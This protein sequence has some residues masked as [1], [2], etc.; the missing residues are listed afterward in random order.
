MDRGELPCNN[1][2]GEANALAPAARLDWHDQ[3]PL[4]NFGSIDP[5]N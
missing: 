1:P 3:S 4:R 2:L 5:Y